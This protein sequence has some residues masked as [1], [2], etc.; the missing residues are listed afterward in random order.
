MPKDRLESPQKREKLSEE[1]AAVIGGLAKG[2]SGRGVWLGVGVSGDCADRPTHRTLIPIRMRKGHSPAAM[3]DPN[4]HLHRQEQ[5]LG[6]SQDDLPGEVYRSNMANRE[7]TCM[8]EMEVLLASRQST[9][10]RQCTVK[11]SLVNSLR[12][13]S[14][15]GGF[16]CWTG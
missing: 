2:E 9:V 13:T 11:F 6:V 8:A 5:A 4:K 10:A 16:L 15:R 3:R 14:N 1:R 7:R 12:L